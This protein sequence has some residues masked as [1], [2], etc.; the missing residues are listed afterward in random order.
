M[1]PGVPPFCAGPSPA[2]PGDAKRERILQAALQVFSREGFHRATIDEVARVARVG[3]GT[4]YLYVSSKEA[5][6]QEAL[7]YAGNQHLTQVEASVAASRDPVEKLSRMFRADVAFLLNHADAARVLLSERVGIGFGYCF[8]EAVGRLRRRRKAL[9]TA[10]IR[11]GQQEGR[12]DPSLPPERVAAAYMGLS[13]GLLFDVLFDPQPAQDPEE[14]A[15]LFL[16]IFLEGIAR[17]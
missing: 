6:L 1:E 14:L 7:Q 9:L 5:L 10:I 8:H 16:G 13:S 15:D 3:K 11:E 2:P 17:R 12:F 4:I